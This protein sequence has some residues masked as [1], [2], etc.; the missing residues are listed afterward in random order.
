MTLHMTRV[1]SVYDT[2]ETALYWKRKYDEMK[3][4]PKEKLIRGMM[5]Q[6]INKDY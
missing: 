6:L 4:I 3:V 5:R 2:C 1:V